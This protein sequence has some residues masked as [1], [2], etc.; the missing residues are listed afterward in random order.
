MDLS[1]VMICNLSASRANGKGR[2]LR[3]DVNLVA[4]HEAAPQVACRAEP[5]CDIFS[6]LFNLGT[7]SPLGDRMFC[8]IVTR[9]GYFQAA[10]LFETS[11]R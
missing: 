1:V 4:P 3:H 10:S 11:L 5:W 9:N 8:Q 6:R 2:F 7:R